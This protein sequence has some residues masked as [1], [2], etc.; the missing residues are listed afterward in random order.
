MSHPASAPNPAQAYEDFL[1]P[2]MFRPWGI[3]LVERASPRAG[4]RVLDVACGS[5]VIARLVAQRL[6]GQVSTAGLDFSPPMIEVAKQAAT[7]EN[8]QIEWYVGNAAAL[9]FADAS[10]DLVLIQ[11]GLQFFPDRVA[12]AREVYRVLVPGGRVVTATWT[13]IE[14]SP[15]LH[16]FAQSIERHLGVPAMYTPFSLG[17][18]ADLRAIFT[19]AGFEEIEIARLSKNVRFPSAEQYIAFGTAG[20]AAAVPALQAMDAA[21]RRQLTEAIRDDLTEAIRQHT[22]GDELV[23]VTESHLTTARKPV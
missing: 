6:E 22:E 11:Q 21:Q 12:A 18:E 7:R 4:E 3:E 17:S 19:E 9:P 10:F 14:N 5:G 16:A 15:F 20:A 13:D 1:V 23:Y 2:G 8:L